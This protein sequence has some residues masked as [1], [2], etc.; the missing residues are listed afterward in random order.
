MHHCID[1][2][3][4]Y[5]ELKI[6]INL[7]SMCFTCHVNTTRIQVNMSSPCHDHEVDMPH[8]QKYKKV[9]HLNFPSQQG[10]NTNIWLV[11]LA[12][13][14]NRKM[15][16]QVQSLLQSVWS[17]QVQFGHIYKGRVNTQLGVEPNYFLNPSCVLTLPLYIWLNWTCILLKLL[18]EGSI[19]KHTSAFLLWCKSNKPVESWV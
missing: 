11:Y 2:G 13:N 19:L 9:A 18:Q 17:I 16:F 15:C 4:L 7:C 14:H 6:N 10:Q 12:C 1:G 5:S 3:K 8:F